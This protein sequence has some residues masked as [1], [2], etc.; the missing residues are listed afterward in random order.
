MFLQCDIAKTEM[1]TFD[2]PARTFLPIV[3]TVYCTYTETQL[4]D[5]RRQGH[6]LSEHSSW[7]AC[8]CHAGGLCQL[9]MKGLQSA[10]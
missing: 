8:S 9:A 6:P 1:T 7:P 10:G 5:F 4:L 3:Y 2:C